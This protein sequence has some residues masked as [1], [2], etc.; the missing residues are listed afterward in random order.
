M[1]DEAQRARE[2]A[3]IEDMLMYGHGGGRYTRSTRARF[4]EKYYRAP[5]STCWLWHGCTN[6]D[7]YGTFRA[8]N[9]CFA[10]HR[11]AYGF[12]IGPIPSEAHVLHECDTPH[13]VNPDHLFLGDQAINMRD[14]ARKGRRKGKN[15]GE[16]NGRCKLS[17][18]QV[19]AIR[20][21]KRGKWALAKIYPVSRATIGAIKARKLW[22]DYD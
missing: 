11:L 2:A 13:C 18:E 6:G 19:R 14:M 15:S 21:D 8:Y 17:L 16:R 9:Q 20:A 3:V 5:H 12:Y 7:G 10:A 1:T 4:E 22:A